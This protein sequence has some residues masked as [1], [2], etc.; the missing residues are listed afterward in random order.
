MAITRALFVSLAALLVTASTAVAQP[1][2]AVRTAAGPASRLISF[3]SQSPGTISSD[4]PISGLQGGET[5]VAIDFL[6]GNTTTMYGIGSTSRLYTINTFTAVA[7][8]V[9]S[10][11]FTT[12]LSGS[13]FGFRAGVTCFNGGIEAP[14]NPG[15]VT[16]DTGQLLQIDLTNASVSSHGPMAYVSG[17]PH[18]GQSPGVAGVAQHG[19]NLIALDAGRDVFAK[20]DPDSGALT[21]LFPLSPAS[22]PTASFAFS[23]NGNP[24][25][26]IDVMHSD[27]YRVDFPNDG[28]TTLL[29]TIGGGSPLTVDSIA[30]P[31]SPAQLQATPSP[32]DFGDQ[33]LGLMSPVHTLTIT[34]MG[35]D[36]LES[37]NVSTSGPAKDDFFVTTDWC[38][39][40]DPDSSREDITLRWPGDSCT[41]SLRFAPSALGTRDAVYRFNEP[42]CCPDPAFFQVPLTGNGVDTPIGPTGPTGPAGSTGPTGPG[43]ADGGNGANGSNGSNGADG[44]QGPPGPIGP[45]G[46]KGDKGDQ[47]PPGPTG[48]V[49][50]VVR[51]IKTK[52]K[53]TCTVKFAS[54]QA[55]RVA[56]RLSRGGR[57]YA[58]G[59]GRR[60]RTTELSMRVVR[61]LRA[62]A[63][64]RLTIVFR[65]GRDTTTFHRAV[66]L[67][68]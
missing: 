37:F 30:V 18:F 21:T 33:P 58:L 15:L 19:D 47:G 25:A 66:R 59:L 12:P 34:L 23:P 22:G 9:G 2:F 8:Q 29:G 16:S 55:A 1:I 49:T 44:S 26:V 60:H 52:T 31:P 28:A 67:T 53:V 57:L 42:R 24:F 4:D 7:T 64:Y 46:P 40:H 54:A 51:R 65:H 62:G 41:V 6:Y 61:P 14:C 5:I 48:K 13:K 11:T 39:N 36:A 35:G 3:D 32:V 68:R 63:T 17:D 50:C 38:A 27:L 56:A 20:L 45:Q 43:G 10:G